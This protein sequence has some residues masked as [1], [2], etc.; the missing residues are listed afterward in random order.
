MENEYWCIMHKGKV[1]E[2]RIFTSNELARNV[3]MWKY[4]KEK[5]IETE[6]NVLR[7][8]SYGSKF[9]IVKLT[10]VED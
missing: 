6:K 7:C 4:P 5:F 3:L 10:T 8:K 9:E 1:L 2:N